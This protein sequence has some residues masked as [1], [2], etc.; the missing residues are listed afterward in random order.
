MNGFTLRSVFKRMSK[1]M[2]F[3]REKLPAPLLAKTKIHCVMIQM[4]HLHEHREI[5]IDTLSTPPTRIQPAPITR[6]VG[7]SVIDS[8]I[9]LLLYLPIIDGWNKLYVS[10]MSVPWTNIAY[11]VGITFGYYFVLEWLFAST[12][13]KKL[14]GLRVVGKDGDECS[15]GA[16]FKRNIV[17]FLDWLPLFYVIGAISLAVSKDRQRLGDRI[18][19]TVVTKAPE[20][21]INP[22]PAPFLFH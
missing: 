7:A 1:P 22:P 5:T 17:R 6:R 14:L 3:R 13:G 4:S 20:K 12:I 21:D 19:S 2:H 16:S 11:L 10:T 8:I 9:N 18:A 15:L